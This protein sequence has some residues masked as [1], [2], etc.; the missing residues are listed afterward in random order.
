MRSY[1]TECVILV[2]LIGQKQGNKFASSTVSFTIFSK[3]KGRLPLLF[4]S[5]HMQ[6]GIM[7][8]V[9]FCVRQFSLFLNK[10]IILSNSERSL[11]QNL[12]SNYHS[13][14]LLNDCFFHFNDLP[15]TKTPSFIQYSTFLCVS[16]L[17]CPEKN[18]DPLF[19]DDEGLQ[20]G[21]ERLDLISYGESRCLTVCSLFGCLTF[22]AAVPLL[23]ARSHT[24][25]VLDLKRNIGSS[26]YPRLVNNPARKYYLIHE[27]TCLFVECHH[28]AWY[29]LH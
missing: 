14:P 29:L 19:T 5:L 7:Y 18:T 13:L 26:Y 10:N 3:K 1:L 8:V 12:Y 4:K 2:D 15:E 20:R 21:V 24:H 25:P 6:Q 28:D 11:N 23:G 9:S 22:F 27:W 17:W 16:F